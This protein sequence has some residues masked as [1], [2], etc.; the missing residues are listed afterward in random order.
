M[1]KISGYLESNKE[2]F[3]RWLVDNEQGRVDIKI[4]PYLK[5]IENGFFVEAGALDG[6]FMSNTKILEDLGWN[7]LLIEPSQKAYIECVK[8]RSGLIYNTALVSKDYREK[9]IR[10]DFFYDGKD[11]QG[12]WSGVMRNTYTNQK[13]EVPARTLQ[14]IFDDQD[15]KKVDFLS[16]DVEGYEFNVLKG[17]DFSKVDVTFI[18]VEVNSVIYSLEDMDEYLEKFGYKRLACLSNF[19]K[20]TNEGWDGSHQDYLYQISVIPN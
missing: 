10:G 3:K 13:V 1:S 7:G 16:L 8:N 6:L 4:L 20:E 5:D 2:E 15:I 12:A 14:S 19:T 11:G 9:T 17:I 18:L